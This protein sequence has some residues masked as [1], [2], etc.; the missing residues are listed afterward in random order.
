MTLHG[1]A[2]KAPTT[3]MYLDPRG[4]V[5]AC[6]QNLWQRLGNITETSLLEMWRG[7]RMDT[8]RSA[9]D[10]GDLSHG[11]ERC[12]VHIDAGHP[13]AAYAR[14]F[15]WLEPDDDQPAWPRQLEFALSNACNLQCTMCNG[16][17]S[18]AI[19]VHRE[20][21]A[22]LPT[23]YD[24]A[25]F[26]ELDLFLPHLRSAAFLGGEPFLGRESLR[27]MHRLAEL[28]A[29]PLCSIT[30]NGT[31]WNDRIHRIVD[32]LPM[33][34]TVSIDAVS[35][36]LFESIRKGA[37]HRVVLTNLDRFREA[38]RPAGGRVSVA[39]CMMRDNWREFGDLLQWA[40]QLDVDVF[41]NGV[42]HPPEMSMVHATRSELVA[43]VAA[44]DDQ[45]RLLQRLLGRNLDVWN[46]ELGVL[47]RLA[48]RPAL[49]TPVHL[50]VT[51]PPTSSTE[52]LIDRSAISA[53]IEA[54]PS[55]VVSEVDPGRSVELGLDL[56][57]LV[58]GSMWEIQRHLCDALGETDF[59][60]LHRHD[61]GSEEFLVRLVGPGSATLLTA[62]LTPRPDGGSTWVLDFEPVS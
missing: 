43:I 41:V 52:L 39:F 50:S 30:T 61:D 17:L 27:V 35:T 6:C 5:R 29:P 8:L 49:E 40:D 51:R 23:V 16:D 10:G 53:R 19:R 44:L 38:V 4:E 33:H 55:H 15:D 56:E 26:Q 25:F 21:R 1:P 37:S 42:S 46:T 13:E 22:P 3:S 2:C 59:S 34:V 47:R 31:Q 24:D 57:S 48:T 32:T 14:A 9:V 28:P 7:I 20:G 36:A 11:C 12:A 18:S 45:D 58:G 54:D 62:L 60:R